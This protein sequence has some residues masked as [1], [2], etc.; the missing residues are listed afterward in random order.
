MIELG[1]I[2]LV[3]PRLLGRRTE[4]ERGCFVMLYTRYP[5]KYGENLTEPLIYLIGTP[6][7]PINLPF[8]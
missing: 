7:L 6:T 2:S 1:G 4:H 5:I 8:L 3:S